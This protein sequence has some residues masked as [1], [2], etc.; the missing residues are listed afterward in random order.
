[1]N[2]IP[3]QPYNPRAP[4]CS[5]RRNLPHWR[6]DGCTYFVTFRLADSIPRPILLEWETERKTWLAAHGITDGLCG[7]DA[8]ERYRAIDA[9]ECRAFEKRQAHR[10]HLELDRSHGNCLLAQADIQEAVQVALGHFHGERCWCGDWVIMPNHVHWLL[11][12]LSGWPLEGLLRSIKGFVSVTASAHG[13]KAGRLWQAESYDRIVRNRV[14]LEA[15]RK[16]I[17]TNPAKAH[18]KPGRFAVYQ[19]EW[20]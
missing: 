7:P 15:Y 11:T 9:R 20:S 3:F 18:V 10:L 19:A 4:V 13:A 16:Y 5:Y 14:E 2:R 12:P 8:A 1:M 6:Q 17:A